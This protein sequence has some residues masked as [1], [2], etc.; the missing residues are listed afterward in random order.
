MH[1]ARN[2]PSTVLLLLLVSIWNTIA[3]ENAREPF[4][5]HPP[6]EKA[7]WREQIGGG[8]LRHTHMAEFKFSRGFGFSDLGPT[9]AHDLWLSHLQMGTMLTGVL[10]RGHWYAGNMEGFGQLISGWQDRPSAA[11]FFGLN[12]GLRYHFATGTRFIPYLGFSGGI[13][14]T[15]I[16]APDLGGTFQFNQ[17]Y[18]AGI[19]YF[20]NSRNA[21]SLEYAVMHISSAGLSDPNNGVNAHLVSLGFSRMF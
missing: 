20:F 16:H 8:F 15:D 19:R 9:Q 14:A 4:P 21:L 18:A 2:C 5:A 10:G 13:S 11:Y 3:A 7:I 12:L 6:V 17:Q 1:P